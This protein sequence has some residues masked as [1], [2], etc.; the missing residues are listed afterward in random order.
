MTKKI[1]HKGIGKE[2]VPGEVPG[3][4]DTAKTTKRQGKS[5]I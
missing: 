4:M 1:K 5:T 2:K 3:A